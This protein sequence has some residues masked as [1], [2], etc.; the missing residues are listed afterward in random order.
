MWERLTEVTANFPGDAR[1]Y[2][3]QIGP[4]APSLAEA[5]I[6]SIGERTRAEVFELPFLRCRFMWRRIL[7]RTVIATR[8]GCQPDE[9][10]LQSSSM[11]RPFV[12]GAEFDFS[13]SHSRDV[14]LI[15]VTSGCGRIGVDIEAVVAIPDQEQ[16]AEIAFTTHEQ[17]ELRR[18]DLS[19]EA[20]YRIWT[21]KEACLKAIGTGFHLDPRAVDIGIV[22]LAAPT[23]RRAPRSSRLSLMC[24]E[25]TNGYTAAL[26]LRQ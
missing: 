11:G 19:S 24:F 23:V 15:T 2:L 4:S 25:P 16:I 14:A 17:S 22:D 12:A 18:Y 10:D 1:V 9:V 26:A 7:L 21:C 5:S 13:M 8:L 20:F 3:A 6:L